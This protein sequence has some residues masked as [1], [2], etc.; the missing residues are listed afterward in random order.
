MTSAHNLGIKKFPD[1]FI[2]KQFLFLSV[3]DHFIFQPEANGFIKFDTLLHAVLLEEME[4][5]LENK[6]RSY[7]L[8]QVAWYLIFP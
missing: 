2:V 7:E 3:N 8:C 6:D 4:P 5:S 1:K